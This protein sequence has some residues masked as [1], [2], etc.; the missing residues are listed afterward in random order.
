VWDLFKEEGM[1]QNW[2]FF[3]STKTSTT[4]VIPMSSKRMYRRVSVNQIELEW[5]QERS[6]ELGESG[7]SV[8]LDIAKSEIVVVVRWGSGTFERPW[9]VKT[10]RRLVC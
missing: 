9:S 6:I 7:T 2:L 3:V 10:R 5:L 4:E 8:G 1:P